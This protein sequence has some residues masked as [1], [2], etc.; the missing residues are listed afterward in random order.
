M[1]CAECVAAGRNEANLPEFYLIEKGCLGDADIILGRRSQKLLTLSEVTL[2]TLL[3][4]FCFLNGL[5]Y[6]SKLKEAHPS[7]LVRKNGNLDQE[8][9]NISCCLFFL[10]KLS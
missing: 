6:S 7:F 4:Q 2:V 10:G 3:A 5:S 9:K 1:F 8:K